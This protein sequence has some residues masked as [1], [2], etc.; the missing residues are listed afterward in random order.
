MKN[1][2]NQY[3]DLKFKDCQDRTDNEVRE[4]LLNSKDCEKQLD[5]LTTSKEATELESVAVDVNKHTKNT[6]EA[7]LHDAID[8]GTNRGTAE[9]KLDNDAKE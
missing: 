5:V 4:N 6:F 2:T 9:I 7:E 1:V 8:V 3:R